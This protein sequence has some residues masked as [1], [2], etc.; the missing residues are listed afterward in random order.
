MKFA[1]VSGRATLVIDGKAVDIEQASDGRIGSDPMV[2]SDLELHSELAGLAASVDPA[3]WP[4]L[5]PATLGAPVP[6]E[7]I[8]GG[9]QLP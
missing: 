1:N 3:A 9:A 2:Y 8:R 7:R 4:T 5:D 6:T